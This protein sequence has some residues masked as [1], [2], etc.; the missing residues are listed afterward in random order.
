MKKCVKVIFEVEDT[1]KVLESF[2]AQQ[3][4]LFNVEGIGQQ[5]SK[6]VVQVFVCGQEEQVEEFIDILYVGTPKISLKNI[7]IETCTT[8]RLYR[9]VFRV[10]E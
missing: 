2:I 1:Q 10:V 9:G 7:A 6:G 5:I 4:K 8:D 3:A